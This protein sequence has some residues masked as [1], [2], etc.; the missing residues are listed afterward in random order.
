MSLTIK[1]KKITAGIFFAIISVSLL[2]AC[3]R[4]AETEQP[5]AI[6]PTPTVQ[7]TPLP[8]ADRVVL[9]RQANADPNLAAQAETVL[10]ELAVGSGLEFETRDSLI[11]NEVTSDMKVVVFLDRPENLGSLS[12]SAPA[13]QFIALTN[14]DWNPTENVSVIRL[15]K[16]N[17]AFMAGFFA[18]ML[19]PNYRVGA[20]MTAE[21][22]NFNQAFVN[23]VYYYC[24][25]CASQIFPL[26]AYPVIATRPA[27]SPPSA[28]QAA[29]DEIN[30]SKVNVLFVSD[31]AASPELF[32][33]LSTMDVALI[34]TQ[35][36]AEEG[37]S[38]WV[39]TI[40]ADGTAPLRNIWPDIMAGNGGNILNAS[41][42]VA[43][44]MFVSVQ[45]G[46]I[47]LSEGKYNYAQRAMD[48]MR[49]NKIDPLPGN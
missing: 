30:V 24:G 26:N 43:D 48:L 7:P 2:T 8:A 31:G 19:A 10:R 28:W 37:R 9:V 15:R 27:G 16:E 20:L 46:L 38:R 29:F 41:I 3:G 1:N 17:T 39:V 18:A 44:N 6:E 4:A 36:P 40:F 11:N 14:D 33:Y 22:S 42:N 45:D 25:F 21:E 35:S 47:W 49:D 5:A 23:G 32:T 13:S 34:G 12:A